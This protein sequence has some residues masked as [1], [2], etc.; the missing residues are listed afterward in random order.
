[1]FSSVLGDRMKGS[2]DTKG[3]AVHWLRTTGV[4]EIKLGKHVPCQDRSET[5]KTRDDMRLMS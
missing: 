4:E 5:E 1:M 3:V 2:F